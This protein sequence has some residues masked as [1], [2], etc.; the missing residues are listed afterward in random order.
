VKYIKK[1]SKEVKEE[2]K[3]GRNT[4]SDLGK[5]NVKGCECVIF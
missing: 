1:D 4:T 2:W 3:N 5:S